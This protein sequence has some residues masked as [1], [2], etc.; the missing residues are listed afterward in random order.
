MVP[1]CH[2]LLMKSWRGQDTAYPPV[3]QSANVGLIAALLVSVMASS[4]SAASPLYIDVPCYDQTDAAWRGQFV[5]Y[6]RSVRF[7]QGGCAVTSIAMVASYYWQWYCTPDIM[8]DFLKRGAAFTGGANLNFGVAAAKLG[9]RYER[10]GFQTRRQASDYLYKALWYGV[11]VTVE[12]RRGTSSHFVVVTGF[13]ALRNDFIAN[14]PSGGRQVLL[15]RTYG[16][17]LG[18]RTM[19]P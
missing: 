7:S 15:F 18:S 2:S 17:P 14:D 1:H 13:D 3:R 10:Q 9:L 8:N 6:S 19:Y 12:V 4:G 5:G 16:T 11:P